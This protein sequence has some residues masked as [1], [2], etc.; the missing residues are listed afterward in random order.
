MLAVLEIL[1]EKLSR[2]VAVRLLK[3][4]N[5]VSGVKHI[6]DSK[7]RTHESQVVMGD[8]DALEAFC[9]V[10]GILVIIVRYLSI[11]KEAFPVANPVAIYY[12]QALPGNSS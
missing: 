8:M 7:T 3:I 2:D 9:L 11:S 10:G 12:Q 4:V 6:Q 1:E 5:I